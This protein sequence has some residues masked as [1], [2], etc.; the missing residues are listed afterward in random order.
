MIDIKSKDS[1]TISRGNEWMLALLC[2]DIDQSAEL[3]GDAEK[4]G[5]ERDPDCA[6]KWFIR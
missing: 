2:G 4:E 5:G 1:F 6:N 3:F